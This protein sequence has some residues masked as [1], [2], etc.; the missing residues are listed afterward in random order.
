[1]HNIQTA[2]SD[3]VVI[4]KPHLENTPIEKVKGNDTPNCFLRVDFWA[5]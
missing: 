2:S 4:F 3:N 1:M 5:F